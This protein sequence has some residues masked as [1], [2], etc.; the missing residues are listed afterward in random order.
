[1]STSLYASIFVV[2]I[3]ISVLAEHTVGGPCSS[4]NDHTDTST[5]KFSSDCDDTTYC[6]SVNGTCQPRLCRR[7]E[8]PFGYATKNMTLP[9]MCREGTFCPDQG[10][11]CRSL[12]SVGEACQVD[13]DEQCAPPPVRQTSLSN[14]MYS[15]IYGESVCLRGVCTYVDF[16]FMCYRRVILERYCP[17]LCECD[18]GT[19]MHPRHRD[20]HG[21]RFQQHNHTA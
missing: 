8:F 16:L 12:L 18:T 21:R 2:A 10:S 9:P 17:Q 11:G 13:R 20:I 1:M 5:G 4:T 6:T 3:A 19:T 7:D 15:T 14:S